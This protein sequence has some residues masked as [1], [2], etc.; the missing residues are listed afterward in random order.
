MS[1]QVNYLNHFTMVFC[2][3]SAWLNKMTEDRLVAIISGLTLRGF[4]EY[5]K[6][7]APDFN[8]ELMLEKEKQ[9][10]LNY[11]SYPVAAL[12]NGDGKT[13]GH[14]GKEYS[15]HIK[16][17]IQLKNDCKAVVKDVKPISRC[18]EEILCD[19]VIEGKNTQ[20]TRL[21]LFQFLNG[22]YMYYMFTFVIFSNN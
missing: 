11:G 18:G 9:P 12:K 20:D 10:Y 1:F 8:E 19:Y 22:K 2:L 21:V 17:L 14:V 6:Y 7:W 16:R 3:C 4:R 5:K 15:Y 13:V